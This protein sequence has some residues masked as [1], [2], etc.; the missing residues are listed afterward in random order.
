MVK[1]LHVG[2][3]AYSVSDDNLRE[4]FS[5]FGTVQSATVVKDRVSGRSKGFGFVE[6]STDAEAAAAIEKMNKVE[7]GGRTMFVSESRSTGAPGG[8]GDRGDRRDGNRGGGGGFG[9]G[10][11]GGDRDGGG[12]RP[13]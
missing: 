2:N 11:R 6:M 9:G 4:A 3:L 10:F 1:K 13:R 8:G 7:L 12:R 5:Q